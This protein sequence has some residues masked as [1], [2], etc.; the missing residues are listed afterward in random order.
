MHNI[1][2][3]RDRQRRRRADG[4]HGETDRRIR[5]EPASLRVHRHHLHECEQSVQVFFQAEWDFLLVCVT[6]IWRLSE[7]MVYNVLSY[8]VDMSQEMLS[9]LPRP[10]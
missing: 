2:G 5:H 8:T 9:G 6:N 3:A 7:T 4:L 10:R 1:G